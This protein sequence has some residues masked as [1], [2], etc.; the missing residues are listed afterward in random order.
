MDMQDSHQEQG[1]VGWEQRGQG[2]VQSL[3]PN[4]AGMVLAKERR[5]SP[6]QRKGGTDHL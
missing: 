3:V 4:Q 6:D 1:A 2:L 5:R